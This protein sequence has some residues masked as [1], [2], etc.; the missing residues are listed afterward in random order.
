MV[1]DR[2]VKTSVMGF[3]FEREKTSM[4]R[5]ERRREG[6]EKGRKG[7]GKERKREGKEKGRKG[8]T[9]SKNNPVLTPVHE[10][11]LFASAAL[12]NCSCNCIFAPRIFFAPPVTFC[13]FNPNSL[14]MKRFTPALTASSMMLT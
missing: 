4:E 6:K 5:E 12:A 10:N 13:V 7:K 11:P 2:K 14:G 9:Q 1:S 3:G 8:H